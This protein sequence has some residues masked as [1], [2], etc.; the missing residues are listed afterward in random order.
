MKTNNNKQKLVITFNGYPDNNSP[1]EYIFDIPNDTKINDIEGAL[2]I[3]EK[4]SGSFCCGYLDD[5][6]SGTQRETEEK[7][8][9]QPKCFWKDDNELYDMGLTAYY[10]YLKKI[11]CNKLKGKTISVIALLEDKSIP[12]EPLIISFE[13]IKNGISEEI[14]N[15]DSDQSQIFAGIVI[16]NSLEQFMEQGKWFIGLK[17]KSDDYIELDNKKWVD[18]SIWKNETSDWEPI[19]WFGLVKEVPN[20]SWIITRDNEMSVLEYNNETIEIDWDAL[21]V[22][23]LAS[24]W[25]LFEYG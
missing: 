19:V 20:E 9:P 11:I 2:R 22:V 24:W 4:E 16:A 8:I 23:D 13:R 6:I 25:Y 17:R 12:S 21:G 14:D 7:Y 10:N 1:E 5:I 3:G 18:L 15:T